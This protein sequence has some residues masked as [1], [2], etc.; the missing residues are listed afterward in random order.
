MSNTAK[1]PN[2]VLDGAEKFF[3]F[4]QLDELVEFCKEDA[5]QT[6]WLDEG[7]QERRAPCAYPAH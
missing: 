2:F 1:T 7:M 6:Q 5:N 3:D 4:G